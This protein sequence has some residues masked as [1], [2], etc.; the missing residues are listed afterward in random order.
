MELRKKRRRNSVCDVPT[1]S[2]YQLH[3]LERV[4]YAQ[5]KGMAS[6]QCC[7]IGKAKLPGRRGGRGL[8]ALISSAWKGERMLVCLY[9]PTLCLCSLQAVAGREQRSSPSCMAQPSW[10]APEPVG[11]P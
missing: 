10:D 11:S 8:G 2:R 7:S 1:R 9:K 4:W 6:W 5:V 3:Y